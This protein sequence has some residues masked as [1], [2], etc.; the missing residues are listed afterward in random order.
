MFRP[1]VIP[2]EENRIGY[3]LPRDK[4]TAEAYEARRRAG[5]EGASAEEEVRSVLHS[6]LRSYHS[7][8]P[9]PPSPP[10]LLPL[11]T[12]FAI[13]TLS[14]GTNLLAQSFEFKYV[15]DYEISSSR[16]LQKEYVL[17]FDNGLFQTDDAPS[18][19]RPAKRA[20]GAYYATLSEAQTL[21]KRRP[22]VRHPS[23]L[24]FSPR[25]DFADF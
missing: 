17:C 12:S 2:G 9:P 5:P 25:A 8:S 4:E 20:K 22:R 13:V 6:S 1:V 18:D 11:P 14:P 15:R 19:E 23:L 24:P 10:P 21:R 7:P 16:K 3:Y